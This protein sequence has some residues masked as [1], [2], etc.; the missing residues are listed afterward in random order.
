[1]TDI[2]LKINRKAWMGFFALYLILSLMLL[3][4]WFDQLASYAFLALMGLTASTL[5]TAL[6][7]G[8]FNLYQKEVTLTDLG[9]VK[10]GVKTTF[11][12]YS[13]ITRMQVGTRGFTL[14][15]NNTHVNITTMYPN[16][17]EARALLLQKIDINEQVEVNGFEWLK[18][19]Y[20]HAG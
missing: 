1:L 14:Y 13:D 19:K 4:L 7:V 6:T 9:I 8:I 10:T 20:L 3:M 12:P 17:E 16:F 5:V 15:G 11:L 18:Q 2:T